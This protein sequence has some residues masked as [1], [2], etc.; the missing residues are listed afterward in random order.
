MNAGVEIQV[1][2]QGTDKKSIEAMYQKL[3]QSIDDAPSPS[4]GLD[5]EG[6]DGRKA[7]FGPLM[8]QVASPTV[9]VVEVPSAPGKYSQKLG[10]LDTI[11]KIVCQG[12]E[13]IASL[14][15]CLPS[16]DVHGDIFDLQD[17]TRLPKNQYW[18]LRP[19]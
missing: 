15:K 10:E 6:T 19:S 7:M 3:R 9:S 16:L 18:V 13:D 1:V 8:V 5:C 4:I 17:M 14:A 11:T 12:K 2:S